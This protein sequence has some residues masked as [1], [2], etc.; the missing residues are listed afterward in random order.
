MKNVKRIICTALILA[1]S[2]LAVGCNMISK[3]PEAI[4]KSAVA[5]V[6]GTKITK[7]QFD[8]K[9]KSA[10]ESLKSQYGTDIETTDQGKQLIEQQKTSVLDEMILEE[11]IM[12]KATEKKLVPKDADLKTEVDKNLADIK[13]QMGTDEQYKAALT[14]AGFTEATLK[15]Y[16]KQKVIMNK[17]RDY[18]VK[19]VKVTDDQVQQ[20]YN[21]NKTKYTEK[22]DTIHI[23][24]I[25]VA[26]EAEALAVEARITKGESFEAVAKEVSTDTGSKDQGGDLGEV[27]YVDSGMDETFMK[28]ALVLKAGEVSQPVKTQFGYHVIKCISK[29]EYP[30]KTFDAVKDDIKK[31]LLSTA[32]ETAFSKATDSWKKAAKIVKYTKNM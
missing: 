3:T 13:T 10:I 20:E 8:E 11:V 16:L 12:Q 17:V 6:N 18:A 21:M 28:G 31:T 22:P 23:Q 2:Q 26:T 32:Q 1:V 24:H 14:Q 30:Y 4:K 29:T 7:A 27:P 25:L 9:M 19:D 15:D 5:T